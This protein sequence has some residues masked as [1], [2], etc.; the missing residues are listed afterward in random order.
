MLLSENSRMQIAVSFLG[1]ILIWLETLG[2][3]LSGQKVEPAVPLTQR[4][5]R[6]RSMPEAVATPH[7]AGLYRYFASCERQMSF[8]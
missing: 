4:L 1:Y 8:C 7:S 6:S 2:E 5:V 3:N